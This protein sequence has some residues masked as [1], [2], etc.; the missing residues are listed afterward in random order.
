L[1]KP[2]RENNFHEKVGS[3]QGITEEKK[4]EAGYCPEWAYQDQYRF[5]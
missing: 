2:R 3:E 5:R 4:K 1:Q